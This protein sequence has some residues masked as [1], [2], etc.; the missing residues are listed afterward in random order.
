MNVFDKIYIAS[1]CRRLQHEGFYT[2]DTET[3]GLDENGRIVEV[4]VIAPDNSHYSSLVNPGIPIPPDAT[5]VHGITD[6][7]VKSEP[8][9]IQV[10]TELTNLYGLTKAK[11]NIPNLVI[12]SSDYDQ[13]LME[14]SGGNPFKGANVFCAMRA[15]AMF[16]GETKEN[17]QYKWQKLSHAAELTGFAMPEGLTA[18]RAYA[19]C[20]MTKHLIEH[21]AAWQWKPTEQEARQA[22]A[23]I[24]DTYSAHSLL[25]ALLPDRGYTLELTIRKS[26][27]GTKQDCNVIYSGQCFMAPHW[28]LA[29][30]AVYERLLGQKALTY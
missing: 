2:L 17:G 15:F 12:Y 29:V 3:T 20:L 8:D 22:I 7:A 4:A 9:W 26:T 6:E 11:E 28:H 10:G 19:D 1:E 14:Q 25:D 16:H 13:Q 23:N 30:Q 18:H 5:N 24:H 21:M 27:T